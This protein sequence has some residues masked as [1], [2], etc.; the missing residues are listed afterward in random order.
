M[1][2]FKDINLQDCPL[3]NGPAILEEEEGWCYYV[4][5]L[6]CGCH[7]AESA[8]NSKKEKHTAAQKAADLWNMGKVLPSNP[9]E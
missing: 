5:C 3:C 1:D 6:D 7:T 8:F 9:G 2:Y 4:M